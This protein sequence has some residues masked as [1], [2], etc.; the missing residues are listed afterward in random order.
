M[1][2]K[3]VL[4]AW[5]HFDQSR[6]APIVHLN[7]G[8]KIL[9]SATDVFVITLYSVSGIQTHQFQSLL[10]CECG[11]IWS[12]IGE[13]EIPNVQKVSIPSQE[14]ECELFQLLQHMHTEEQAQHLSM[15]W[16]D[17]PDQ[18]ANSCKRCRS[19]PLCMALPPQRVQPGHSRASVPGTGHR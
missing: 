19:K 8:N 5:Q 15:A 6:T 17:S 13:N 9:Q 3:D 12:E 10:L 14:V 7:T 1:R 16:H 2:R 11:G 4:I 18:A